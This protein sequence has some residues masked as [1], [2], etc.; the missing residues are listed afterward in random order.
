MARLVLTQ[1]GEDVTVGGDVELFGTVSGGE[2]ITVVSGDIILDASFNRGGDTIFLPG[3]AEEYTASTQGSLVI[4]TR[5]DGS[6]SLTIPVGTAGTEIVFGGDDSR[7]LLIDTVQGRVELDGEPID[8]SPDTL[9]PG[10]EEVATTFTV[11]ANSPT[12]TEGDSGTRFLTYTITLNETPTQDVT[13]NFVTTTGGTAEINDDF[14]PVSGTVTIA[15]GTNT[16]FVSVPIL[17]DTLVEGNETVTLQLSG[18]ALA[19]TTTLTGTIID[20]D[21]QQTVQN[22]SA[23]SEVIVGTESN[24]TFRASNNELGAGDVVQGLGGTDTLQ[25]FVDENAAGFGSI[26]YSAFELDSVERV[27][28]TN[29]GPNPVVLDMSGAT[30]VQL[31]GSVNSSNSVTFNQVATEADV[32]VDNLTV[33]EGAT[34][35]DVSVFY[36][37]E[38]TATYNEVNVTVSNSDADDIT[39]GTV[40]NTGT[41]TNTGIE[42]VNL[43]VGG[44]SSIETLDTELTTLD[45][46]GSGDLVIQDALEDTVRSIDAA[47]LAGDVTISFR[48]NTVG[49]T[50]E[51]SAQD[52]N[53]TA[54]DG[55][56]D[57]D[58]NAGN[59]TVLAF[60]G[61]DNVDAGAGTNTVFGGLGNDV[62]T[63]TNADGSLAVGN[64]TV[65][66]EEGDDS[67]TLGNGSNTIFA[68]VGN[69]TVVAGDGGNFVDAGDG[70]DDVTLGSGADFV[71]T[72]GGHDIIRTGDGNDV[73]V[74]EGNFAG[75]DSTA[76]GR[77]DDALY[78]GTGRDELR[79]DAGAEDLDFSG[80]YDLEILTLTSAGTTVL[81]TQAQRAGI[82]TV[83]GTDGDDVID[84]SA[85]TRGITIVQ[86]AGIDTLTTGSGDDT[87]VFNGDLV[88]DFNDTITAGTGLDT[89]TLNGDIFNYITTDGIDVINLTSDGNATDG[90]GNIYGIGLDGGNADETGTLVINGGTLLADEFVIIEAQFAGAAYAFDITTGAGGDTIGTAVGDFDDN[91]TSGA[92]N[93]FVQTFDGDDNIRLGIGDDT[94][95][96][97]AGA[98]ELYGDLGA[99]T[100]NLGVDADVDTVIYASVSESSVAS[101][102]DTINEF[103][104]GVDQIDISELLENA[105]V[106]DVEFI[107]ANDLDAA[108]AQMVAGDGTISIVF[109]E[110]LPGEPT[111]TGDDPNGFFFVDLNDDG[112]LDGSDLQI[113]I[114]GDNVDPEGDVVIAADPISG[115]TGFEAFSDQ[116]ASGSAMAVESFQIA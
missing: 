87:F 10:N 69:D 98:D 97:G 15:A 79:V 112:E 93:D 77:Q 111:N 80:T 14:T 11:A 57:I 24:D 64:N 51:G 84:A 47:A 53:V 72:G 36:Q 70:G 21:Q 75:D 109:I 94:A 34:E 7:T 59:D 22:L 40:D 33:V 113:F 76:A 8:S 102:R 99:D 30:D 78:F 46:S 66:G 41:Q 29:D 96:A 56:D 91:V 19:A 88:L 108:E 74:A 18:S 60:G 104:S 12:V 55:S 9:S 115:Q 82:D 106:T 81:G 54:G 50:Y 58:T 65:F 32:L 35:S 26:N 67:I 38:V 37:N 42:E 27:L 105:G 116:F 62:I 20:D 61:D 68:G 103:D 16:A 73:V 86:G 5:N 101:G 3:E 85:F 2:E 52:D 1:P 49:V 39:L 4:L 48:N 95:N 6:V 100:L 89:L 31:V 90:D 25:V 83:N 71:I 13:L 23:G 28:V 17:G 110:T 92:G 63:A 114:N 43:I 44:T 45:I 107:S